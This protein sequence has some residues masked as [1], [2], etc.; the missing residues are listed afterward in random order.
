[1][2]RLAE[3]QKQLADAQKRSDQK[4]AELAEAQK[5]PDERLNTLITVVDGVIR[6]RP[7]Q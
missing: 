3:A 7:P 2:A 1:M 6:N 5:H 4:I